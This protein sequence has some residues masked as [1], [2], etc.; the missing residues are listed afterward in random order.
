MKM[1][2]GL[3]MAHET[4]IK[5]QQAKVQQWIQEGQELD[6]LLKEAGYLPAFFHTIEAALERVSINAYNLEVISKG[7]LND[8]RHDLLKLKPL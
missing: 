7:R 3:K 2:G 8:I 1:K 4:Q 5:D 6:R